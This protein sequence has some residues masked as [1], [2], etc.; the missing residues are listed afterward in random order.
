MCYFMYI[1]ILEKNFNFL[2]NRERIGIIIE[3][4]KKKI[5]HLKSYFYKNKNPI[6]S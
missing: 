5:V 4:Q 1:Q 3:I 2:E 6:N